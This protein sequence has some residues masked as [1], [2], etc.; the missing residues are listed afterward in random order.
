MCKDSSSSTLVK[1]GGV[2]GF[3]SLSPSP[4]PILDGSYYQTGWKKCMAYWGGGQVRICVQK[5]IMAN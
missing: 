1:R 5:H 2:P 4:W 3:R